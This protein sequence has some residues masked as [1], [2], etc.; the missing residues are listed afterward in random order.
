MHVLYLSVGW[1]KFINGFLK[2]LGNEAKTFR[3]NWPSLNAEWTGVE[4][5][6]LYNA[7]IVIF[8]NLEVSFYCLQFFILFF[9][10]HAF[11]P[12]HC[13]L[14]LNGCLICVPFICLIS[15]FLLPETN[16]HNFW[17]CYYLCKHGPLVLITTWWLTA[18]MEIRMA[19]I[20]K[21]F[22]CI[23]YLKSL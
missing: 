7:F 14:I 8:P 22:P 19:L 23:R 9:S 11:P 5:L 4:Y 17:Y 16:P 15:P 10:G 2:Q 1:F 18:V 13:S 3:I 20:P 21:K 12:T 6:V